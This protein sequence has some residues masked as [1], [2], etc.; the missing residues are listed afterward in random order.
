MSQDAQSS[1][2][3][4]D[5]LG[6]S[7]QRTR[8]NEDPAPKSDSFL[9]FTTVGLATALSATGTLSV[10]NDR[11]TLEYDTETCILTASVKGAE[12]P[13]VSHAVLSQ[14]LGAASVIAVSD[15]VWG[16]GKAIEIVYSDGSK[17]WVILY[18]KSPFIV[19]QTILSNS[20]PEDATVNRLQTA[21]LKL[22]LGK[23]A[24]GLKAFGT[25]GLSA[26]TGG[27]SYSFLAVADP[28]TRA[29]VVTGWLTHERGS[30]VVFGGTSG[31]S[32]IV[33]ARL[34][35]GRLLLSPAAVERLEPLLVGYFDDARLGLEAY[36]DAIAK[37]YAI[38]LPPQPTVY[39]TWYH[40][41]ASDEKE[42]AV[43]TAFAEKQ[44]APYGLSVMQIDDGCN[45]A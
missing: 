13:F 44:L 42:I 3:V 39:C 24:Y 4:F 15:R 19:M 29:G 35:F 10:E 22:D 7:D 40:S 28:E 14:P 8:N 41:R 18:A 5:R 38:E 31:D 17:D 2:A 11:Y 16:S 43:N 45:P 9:A 36:A 34:D 1:E 12:T 33:R 30:G 32:P 21:A 23:P 25:G 6:L 26:L 37:Q 27:G 20:T